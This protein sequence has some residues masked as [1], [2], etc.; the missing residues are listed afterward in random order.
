[1]W[2][3]CQAAHSCGSDCSHQEG[4]S[5]KQENFICLYDLCKISQVC[6]Q[7]LDIWDELVHYAR[8]CLQRCQIKMSS[9][10]VN[11]VTKHPEIQLLNISTLYR[12]SSQIDVLK[13]VQARGLDSLFRSSSRSLKIYRS[14]T[15]MESTGGVRY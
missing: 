1:M 6:L 2:N 4:G 3:F 7:L 10:G 12:V 5:L 9:Y 15:D 11:L 13:Q 8:P 14:S